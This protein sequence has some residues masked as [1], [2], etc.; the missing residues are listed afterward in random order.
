MRA[1]LAV[2]ALCP[3]SAIAAP[4]PATLH[5]FASGLALPVDIA[6]AADGSD[7][8][9][10]AEQAGRI[11]VLRSGI[12]LATPFLD[13]GARVQSG[14]E[15][16]LL[17][18]TFH[19]AFAANGR[20]F[21]LYTAPPPVANGGSDVVIASARRSASDPDRADAASV[22]ELLRI[23]HPA[24][25]N[26]NGG[27]LAFGPDGF[28]YASIGDGGGGGDPGNLAQN[29]ADLRGKLLRLDVD[30][31]SPYGIPA[32]NPF[33]GQSGARP[34]IFA[35]GLR[36]PWRIAFDR[37]TG[38]LY[39]GDVGQNV[40]E[41]VNVIPAA[42][43]GGQNF[44]WRVFE[45]T[46]CHLPAT[47][48]AL[49]GHVPPVLEYGHAAN[50]G[51][52]ITGGSVYRGR[53]WPEL[54]GYYVYGDYVSGR[55][56]A[57]LPPF[58]GGHGAAIQVATIS[59]LSSF[60]E[61]EAGELYAADRDGGRIVRLGP[62]DADGDGMSNAFEMSLTGSATAA[63]P[64]ADG[65]G[66]G[67]SN[68]DEYR[69]GRNPGLRDNDVFTDAR[70]FASQQYRDF[71]GRRGDEGGIAY[72]ARLLAGGERSRARVAL[73]FFDSPE[74]QGVGAPVVRLYFAYFLRIPDEPGLAYW[75]ARAR[76]GDPL[77]AI[78]SFFAASP[79]FAARYGNLD[80]GAF[81][82]RIY[83]NVLA[84]APDS[85]GR[86]H[87][88]GQLASGAMSRGEVMLAFSQS[89]EFLG[90][91]GSEVYVTMAYVGMLRRS[92]EPEGFRYWTEFVDG[93]NPPAALIEAF[94]AA[95]EY[96]QRFMP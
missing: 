47:G 96:R 33:V 48:C 89:A 80:N 65:D 95:P 57:A 72:W 2:L 49:A 50:G 26:H 76:S 87:W 67:L 64:A 79:E 35:Y 59:A 77:A 69:E 28:L 31:A 24:N 6:H 52:S 90:T 84:R 68:L 34:E 60:G 17:S 13:L 53:A 38:D 25:T 93:G 94:L 15:Q 55:T 36:N 66:D 75:M 39:I 37:G 51:F 30:A 41:E 56:W 19:P 88:V 46:R 7:R 9:F 74:F 18:L 11:R 82:D 5:P 43:P 23:P 71:L 62:A 21:L 73:D 83:A 29:L 70:L 86:A 32:S 20:F 44:G 54:R 40:I 91:V 61:D 12:P 27:R 8:L 85:G 1:G 22:T 45:G 14:G 63:D 78:S 4:G 10:V 92:P 42:S 58:T 81:V 3:L 16:G